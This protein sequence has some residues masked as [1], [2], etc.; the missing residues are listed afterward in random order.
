MEEHRNEDV[1]DQNVSEIKIQAQLRLVI[2]GVTLKE[3]K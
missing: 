3:Q 1:K 2:D